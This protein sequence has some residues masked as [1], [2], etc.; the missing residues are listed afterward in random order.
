MKYYSKKRQVCVGN[1]PSGLKIRNVENYDSPKLVGI[2]M[3]AWGS[4]ETDDKIGEEDLKTYDLVSEM[5]AFKEDKEYII[6]CLGCLISNFRAYYDLIDFKYD[7]I[8]EEVVV[9]MP[10]QVIK[11]SIAGDSGIAILYDVANRLYSACC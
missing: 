10:N 8:T 5:D 2:K 3:Y 1:I 7:P 6:H 4:F 11:Q 9:I